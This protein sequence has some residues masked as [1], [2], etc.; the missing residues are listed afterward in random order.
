MHRRSIIVI[1]LLWSMASMAESRAE[2]RADSTV[3]GA[4]QA[5]AEAVLL[6]KS[7]YQ[8][9]MGCHSL[10]RNR[11]GPLHCGLLGRAAGTVPDYAYSEA[12]VRSGIVWTE[13]TLDAFLASP[14]EV[15]PGTTMGFAGVFLETDRRALIAYLKFANRELC[16]EHL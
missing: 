2:S 16:N 14:L 4:D 8:R 1:L 3:D 6:G 5:P 7:V 11:T 9:C 12:M 10:E 15:V 13:V